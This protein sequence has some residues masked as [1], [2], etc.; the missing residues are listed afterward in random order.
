MD[1]KKLGN[2]TEE[3]KEKSGNE[4][5]REEKDMAG[6]SYRVR[7]LEFVLQCPPLS[8]GLNTYRIECCEKEMKQYLQC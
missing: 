6:V 2:F 8:N 5:T 1:T 4:R 7:D 3:I